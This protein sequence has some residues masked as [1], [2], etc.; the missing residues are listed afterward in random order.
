MLCNTL[1]KRRQAGAADRRG[2]AGSQGCPWSDQS[3]LPPIPATSPWLLH[4]GLGPSSL[5]KVGRCEACA[6]PSAVRA[7][8]PA[9]RSPPSSSGRGPT[10]A[11][12]A[13]T[14]RLS[15]PPLRRHRCFC[16]RPS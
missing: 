15:P 12:T 7:I 2:K 16:R 1:A 5:W 14:A 13:A 9:A 4:L 6:L 10:A 3:S 8:D 11:A